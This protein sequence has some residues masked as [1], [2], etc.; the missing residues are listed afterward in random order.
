VNFYFYLTAIGKAFSILSDSKK[1]EQYDQYGH[2]MEPQYHRGNTHGAHGTQHYYQCDNDDD[3]SAEELFNLFFGH[4]GMIYDSIEIPQI[5]LI[6][7]E[8][9]LIHVNIV[10]NQIHFILLLNHHKMFVFQLKLFLFSFFCC[11]D[12]IHLLNYYL[13]YSYFLFQLL[14][15]YLSVNLNF[16]YNVPG[17]I[18]R[19]FVCFII[20][21]VI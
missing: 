7:Q 8:H 2:A 21:F 3:F 14:E 11:R 9:Q 13:I 4:P 1:R 6:I 17:K 5:F 15:H 12:H 18:Y 19:I 20:E 10:D 16:N